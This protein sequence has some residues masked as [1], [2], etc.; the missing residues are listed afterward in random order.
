[1]LPGVLGMQNHDTQHAINNE[2]KWKDLI[3]RFDELREERLNRADDR[4]NPYLDQTIKELEA[5][6]ER[7]ATESPH[8]E[9]L[10]T[11]TTNMGKQTR[12]G[13]RNRLNRAPD[14]RM[15]LETIRKGDKV[16]YTG[17]PECIFSLEKYFLVPGDT[18]EVLGTEAEDPAGR[19]IEVGWDR[20]FIFEGKDFN[21]RSHVEREDLKLLERAEPQPQ[22]TAENF[23]KALHEAALILMENERKKVK[24]L[25]AMIKDRFPIHTY[26]RDFYNR[27]C[28]YKTQGENI[29]KL[30]HD[31]RERASRRRNLRRRGPNTAR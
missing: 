30:R 11:A 3:K 27:A 7:L 21:P 13:N 22:M 5:E 19:Q 2:Q 31:V 20:T 29:P 26:G 12:R 18:G 17:E 1:M 15:D 25:R 14:G 24:Q 6:L 28:R 23:Q 10:A 16:K 9:R 4:E 8:A